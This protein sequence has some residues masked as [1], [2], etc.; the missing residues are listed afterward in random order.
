MNYEFLICFYSSHL[1][2]SSS[3]ILNAFGQQGGATQALEF[4]L[5]KVSRNFIA[6]HADTEVVIQI[7]S[8]LEVLG[9]FSNIRHA[10][11]SSGMFF[12]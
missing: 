9:R 5:G 11:L 7:I 4:F 2:Y 1:C 6:Y 3:S 10:I 8:L 12:L